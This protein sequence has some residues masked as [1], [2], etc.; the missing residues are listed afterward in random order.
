MYRSNRAVCSGPISRSPGYYAIDSSDE[1]IGR[2]E[3]GG[4]SEWEMESLVWL[5][6]AWLV[7]GDVVEM[8]SGEG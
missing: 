2:N 1:N 4:M 8:L 7:G 3:G 6:W 5:S